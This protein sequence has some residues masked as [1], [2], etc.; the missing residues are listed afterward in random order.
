MNE[1]KW[2]PHQAEFSLT[3]NEHKNSYCSIKE[4]GLDESEYWV[5]EEERQKALATDSVWVIQWYP[6]TPVGFYRFQASTFEAVYAAA[7]A[8]EADE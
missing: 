3:H 4:A 2:P 6:H 7:M 1:F 8:V 5:S